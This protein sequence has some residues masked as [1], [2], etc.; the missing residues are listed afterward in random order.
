M[1]HA[2]NTESNKIY[3]IFKTIIAVEYQSDVVAKSLMTVILYIKTFYWYRQ[4]QKKL[5]N[6]I[7]MTMDWQKVCLISL[8]G[9]LKTIKRLTN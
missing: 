6:S 1:K 3:E 7:K 9:H 5:H 4:A 2:L 8:I